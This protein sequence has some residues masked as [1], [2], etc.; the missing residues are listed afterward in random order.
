[1]PNGTMPYTCMCLREARRA[2]GYQN[3]GQAG[4]AT[5][6]SQEVIGRHERGD[7]PLQ[8]TDVIEYADAYGHP[9]ILMAFCGECKIREALFGKC[10]NKK[11]GLPTSVIRVSNRLRNAGPYADRLTEILDDGEIDKTELTDFHSALDFLQ[12]V[13]EVWRE[14]VTACMSAGIISTKKD[15]SAGTESVLATIESAHHSKL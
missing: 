2:A 4:L 14:L 7:V 12:S 1:M 11:P 9:E 5:H 3:F 10:E 8:I 6:R 15:R 13:E